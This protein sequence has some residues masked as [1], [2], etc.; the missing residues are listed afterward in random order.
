L[1][2]KLGDGRTL[3]YIIRSDEKLSEAASNVDAIKHWG[4][5]WRIVSKMWD[6]K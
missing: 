2:M 3:A 6:F 1:N 5:C 4:M